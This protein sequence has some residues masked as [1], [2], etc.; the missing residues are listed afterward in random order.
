MGGFYIVENA[1][2]DNF[3]SVMREQVFPKITSSYEFYENYI[4]N[5]F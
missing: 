5:N 4:L 1:A 2:M 3:A